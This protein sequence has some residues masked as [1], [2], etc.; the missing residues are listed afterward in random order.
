M[1]PRKQGLTRQQP[2]KK[3]RIGISENSTHCA[4]FLEKVFCDLRAKTTVAYRG[5]PTRMMY[6]KHD[7]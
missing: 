7:I 1:K 2:F 5:F 4:L 3:G 6:L